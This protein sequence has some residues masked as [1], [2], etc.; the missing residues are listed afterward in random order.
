MGSGFPS[1]LCSAKGR[2]DGAQ[3]QR[4]RTQRGGRR[5]DPAA[6]SRQNKARFLS[7]STES[8]FPRPFLGPC[9]SGSSEPLDPE[10]SL[11]LPCWGAAFPW[12]PPKEKLCQDNFDFWTLPFLFPCLGQES[13]VRRTEFLHLKTPCLRDLERGTYEQE[14]PLWGQWRGEPWLP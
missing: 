13:H 9:R 8:C 12:G 6:Q 7:V 1:R 11:G 2:Q 4:G 3:T 10:H 14:R 5:R